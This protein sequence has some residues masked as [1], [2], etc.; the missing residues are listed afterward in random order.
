MTNIS[1]L[2][3]GM[4]KLWFSWHLAAEALVAF[5]AIVLGV[6]PIITISI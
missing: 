1:G 5:Y 3:Q 6:F 2:V 4:E